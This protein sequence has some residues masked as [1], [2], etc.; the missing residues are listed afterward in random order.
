MYNAQCKTLFAEH[1]PQ[2]FKARE[3]ALYE[4]K[5]AELELRRT[6]L[7]AIE[8]LSCK[9]KIFQG[10]GETF[11]YKINYENIHHLLPALEKC[12]QAK[13]ETS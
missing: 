7:K 13:S 8:Q 9:Q 1:A 2:E 5:K 4:V 11:F 12:W 6:Q 10:Y 3:A